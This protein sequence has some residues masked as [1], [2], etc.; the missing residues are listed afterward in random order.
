[1]GVVLGGEVETAEEERAM[2]ARSKSVA[3]I[4]RYAIGLSAVV[5][6]TFGLECVLANLEGLLPLFLGERVGAFPSRLRRTRGR[7][8]SDRAQELLISHMIFG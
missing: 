7:D 1:M 6:R 8:C 2:A 3:K 4:H 5:V